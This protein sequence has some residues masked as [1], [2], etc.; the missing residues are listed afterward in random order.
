[1]FLHILRAVT[2]AVYT[3][4]R[5]K[6][7][8]FSSE[9]DNTGMLS[10]DISQCG[11]LLCLLDMCGIRVYMAGARG[12]AMDLGGCLRGLEASLSALEG[13]GSVMA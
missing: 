10:L 13:G 8:N 12:W 9:T 6:S 3:F 4:E 2:L 11:M 7:R 5:K 1:M